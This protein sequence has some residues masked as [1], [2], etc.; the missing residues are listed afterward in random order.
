[1]KEDLYILIQKLSVSLNKKKVLN[2]FDDEEKE[3]K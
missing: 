2:I 3:E 1:L